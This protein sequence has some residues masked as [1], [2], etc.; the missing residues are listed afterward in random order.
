LE[1]TNV[2]LYGMRRNENAH[3]DQRHDYERKPAE[4]QNNVAASGSEP[5]ESKAHTNEKSHREQS[6]KRNP[7]SQTDAHI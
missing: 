7:N 2:N 5:N 4:D 1:W 6:Y 3:K